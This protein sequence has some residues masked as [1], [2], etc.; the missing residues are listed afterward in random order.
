M[1]VQV[2]TDNLITD[3][4][5]S[6]NAAV[7]QSQTL[8]QDAGRSGDLVWATVMAK[9]SATQKWIPFTNEASTDGTAIPQ[10]IYVGSDITEAVIIA[11]DVEDLEILV[12][13]GVSIDQNLIT[14]ENSKT[15]LTV[16]TVGTTDIRN[17]EDHL[18][19][20]GIFMQDTTEVSSYA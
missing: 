14:I 9:V 12:G 1:P 15:L 17:V 4:I 16:I 6:G 5:R 13:A 18:A 11:G 7:K 3:L 20:I 10:G 8:K 19:E 2:K